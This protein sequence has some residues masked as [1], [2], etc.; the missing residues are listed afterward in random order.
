GSEMVDE[1]DSVAPSRPSSHAVFDAAT[2]D[3]NISAKPT[4]PSTEPKKRRPGPRTK[5]T[6]ETMENIRAGVA[7]GLP[8]EIA[9]RRAGVGKSAFHDWQNRGIQALDKQCKG[10]VLSNRERDCREFVMMLRDAY[11]ERL[12]LLAE[13]LYAEATNH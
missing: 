11:A 10:Q 1:T 8:V 13:R 5:R 4:T 7:A 9:A 2:A 12:A 6:P 3:D